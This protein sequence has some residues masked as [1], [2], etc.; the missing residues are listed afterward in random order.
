L[1]L[2]G[3]ATLPLLVGTGYLLYAL[4]R[5]SYE[6]NRNR[7][8][9]QWGA[10]ELVVPLRRITRVVQGSQLRSPMR[11]RGLRLPGCMIGR[12]EVRGASG[13]P[14][15][16]YAT[17]PLEQQVLLVTPSLSYA[18]SPSMRKEF[19][20][21]LEICRHMGALESPNQEAHHPP[22]PMWPAWRDRTL[23]LLAVTGAVA[24]L[25]QFVYLCWRYET[26]P[27]YLPLHFDPLGNA[28]RI[29]GRAELFR[30]PLIGLAVLLGDTALSGMVHRRAEGAS[31]LLIGGALLMQVL[32]GLGLW[33]LTR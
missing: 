11:W 10:S 7:L 30:L 4:V 3:V 5:F 33:R 32:L 27:R 18:I 22:I 25:A 9:I 31:Y 23:R 14:L 16:T 1:A 19:L 13:G 26:L 24:N 12:G 2:L 29:G 28:D 21:A 20:T 6:L 17:E 15:V 8:L